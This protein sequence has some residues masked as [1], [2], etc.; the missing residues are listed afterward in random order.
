MRILTLQTPAGLANPFPAQTSKKERSTMTR[1]GKKN[2]HGDNWP[3]LLSVEEAA[4]F[5]RL[6]RST[7]DHYRCEGRGPIYRK[8]GAR[9]FYPKPDLIRWSERNSYASTSERLRDP[10]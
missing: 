2:S 4:K 3:E 5:L 9:V 6:K 10:K 7:L 8:H 1:T